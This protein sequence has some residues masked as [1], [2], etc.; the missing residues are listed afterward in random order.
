MKFERK[1]CF[2]LVLVCAV[3]GLCGWCLW[4]FFKKRR[5]KDAKK[6]KDGKTDGVSFLYFM[7]HS[8]IKNVMRDSICFEVW[9]DSVKFGSCTCDIGK[10]ALLAHV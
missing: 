3:V 5:P 2:F 8:L 7:I 4:R 1:F 10:V 6:K 9:V